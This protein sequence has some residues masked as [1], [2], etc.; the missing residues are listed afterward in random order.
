MLTLFSQL[1]RHLSRKVLLGLCPSSLL[2]SFYSFLLSFLF[3]FL[4]LTL[5]LHFYS[6]FSAYILS[7]KSRKWKSQIT[8]NL[9]LHPPSTFNAPLSRVM[10]Y[11]SFRIYILFLGGTHSRRNM[12][13]YHDTLCSKKLVQFFPATYYKYP[14]TNPTAICTW[15]RVPRTPTGPFANIKGGLC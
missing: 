10:F 8:V 15:N 14:L 3:P 11:F 1:L 13:E 6:F 9:E 5:F 2:F 7:S 4:L 12:K